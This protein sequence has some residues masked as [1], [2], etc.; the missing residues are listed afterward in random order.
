MNSPISIGGRVPNWKAPSV[1]A[2]KSQLVANMMFE[3]HLCQNRIS[4]CVGSREVFTLPYMLYGKMEE[5][6]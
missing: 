5:S 1:G 6:V 3:G 4:R 2:F